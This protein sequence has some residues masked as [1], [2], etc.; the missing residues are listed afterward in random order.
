M[1][2]LIDQAPSHKCTQTKETLANLGIQLEL[3][4]AGTTSLV[5]PVD[6]G[7]NKPFKDRLRN[8]WWKW[9][10]ANATLE[11]PMP[12]ATRRDMASWI[13]KAWSDIPAEIVRNSWRCSEYDYYEDD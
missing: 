7:I 11:N 9:V 2:L 13:D 3:I 12:R 6:V 4:P 5:Q 10:V 1:V 8:E